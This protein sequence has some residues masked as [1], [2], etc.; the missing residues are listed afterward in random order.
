M[1]HRRLGS[2]G[3]SV[4]PMALGTMTWGTVLD[5][6]MCRDQLRTFVEAGGNFVDT[7]YG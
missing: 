3:L 2:S 7:A 6:E 4:S 1:R 5:D